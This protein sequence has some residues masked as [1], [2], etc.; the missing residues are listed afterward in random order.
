MLVELQNFLDRIEIAVDWVL[1]HKGLGFGDDSG[2]GLQCE[3]LGQIVMGGVEHV[4][5]GLVHSSSQSFVLT[6]SSF[7]SVASRA[8][9]IP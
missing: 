9:T 3:L 4:Q 8:S 7:L 6:L 1:I 5:G 2:L